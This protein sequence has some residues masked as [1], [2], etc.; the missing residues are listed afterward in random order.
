MSKEDLFESEGVVVDVHPDGRFRI[1]L[2]NGH[3]V[4]AYTSGKMR[5]NRIRMLEGD[6]VTVEMTPYDLDKAR[7]IFRHKDEKAAA[8]T[9]PHRRP[10]RRYR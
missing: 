6:R 4:I 10:M 7:I 9:G 1:R 8:S 3:H 5:K 2:E